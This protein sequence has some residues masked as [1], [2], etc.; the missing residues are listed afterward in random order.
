VNVR[1]DAAGGDDFS[2]ARETSVPAPTIM[3]GV[4]PLITSGLPALPIPAMRLRNADVGFDDAA[5]IHD[6]ALVM[7]RSRRRRR[8]GGRRLAHAVADHFAAAEFGFL[9]RSGQVFFD[10]DE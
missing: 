8:H 1:V 6:H 3:P 10:L 9:A 7:T 4:T 2:F 5:M